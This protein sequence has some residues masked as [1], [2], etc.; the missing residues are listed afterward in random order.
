MNIRWLFGN[1]TDPQYKLPWRQQFSLSNQA[2]RRYVTESTFLSR[3][4]LIVAPFLLL[5]ILVRPGLVYFGYGGRN[6]PFLIVTGALVMLFWPWSA[7]MYRSMYAG[8]I[9]KV[10][11]EVGNDVC[12][13]CG[14]E[15]RGLGDDIKR[16][17]E[18]GANR[19]IPARRA[20]ESEEAPR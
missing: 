1:F 8:P 14:Y 9:R 16:C 11:R 10:M 5:L 3:T 18:C 12:I 19:D 2:H 13:E 20:S 17:P 7:W 15:L 6:L 4:I